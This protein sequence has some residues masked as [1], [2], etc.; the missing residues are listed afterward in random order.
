MEPGFAACPKCSG[1]GFMRYKVWDSIGVIMN[2]LGIKEGDDR[3]EVPVFTV[4]ITCPGCDGSG[5]IDW[6][7][8]ANRGETLKRPF[9]KPEG[10]MDICFRTLQLRSFYSPTH[11][12]LPRLITFPARK[13][14]KILELS[15]VRYSGIRLTPRLLAASL[16]E[17]RELYSSL[18]EYEGFFRTLSKEEV[19]EEIIKAEITKRGLA[20]FMPDKFAYPGPDDFPW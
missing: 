2:L 9:V 8:R 11:Y 20:E 1:R 4:R 17:L 15:Q 14:D 7:W 6:I 12:C 19:T 5:I 18:L 3:G 10:N 13:V 16:D